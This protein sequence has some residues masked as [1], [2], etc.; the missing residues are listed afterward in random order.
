MLHTPMHKPRHR[1][2]DVPDELEPG[3]VP[4][5]PDEGPVPAS[6]PDDAEHDRVIEPTAQQ[7]GAGP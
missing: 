6:I 4:V 5:E 7:A 1:D 3:A 2:R